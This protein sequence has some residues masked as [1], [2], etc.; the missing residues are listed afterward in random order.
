M[1]EGKKWCKPTKKFI[2]RLQLRLTHTYT[3]YKVDGKPC[4]FNVHSWCAHRDHMPTSLLDRS[5]ACCYHH[6]SQCAAEHEANI[7]NCSSPAR[8]RYRSSQNLSNAICDV[9]Y[10]WC[11]W[12]AKFLQIL[13]ITKRSIT[14]CPRVPR[15]N[16]LTRWVPY[17][18][19]IRHQMIISVA[20]WRIYPSWVNDKLRAWE[21]LGHSGM[22]WARLSRD[23]FRSKLE[24]I[25]FLSRVTFISKSFLFVSRAFVRFG[26][27]RSSFWFWQCLGARFETP[28]GH[29]ASFCELR[30]RPSIFWNYLSFFKAE[31][32]L[33]AWQLWW[34]PGWAKHFG[35]GTSK[36][37]M[38]TSHLGVGEIERR[39]TIDRCARRVAC[40]DPWSKRE[41]NTQRSQ[42]VI[43]WS[44]NPSSSTK[45]A[46]FEEPVT[47]TWCRDRFALHCFR[48]CGC[49]A[50]CR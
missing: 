35:D 16:Y 30:L 37:R 45:P 26:A 15:Q 33:L 42:R 6:A 36:V 46:S 18:E 8:Y 28:F 11:C 23:N 19:Y 27:K 13:K 34:S 9:T 47:K 5:N 12:L 2:H 49:T 3:V 50:T 48:V 17:D 25:W 38:K 41:K 10:S 31:P 39:R 29:R 4:E 20:V 7:W 14:V 32:V 44:L 22:F 40:G 1:I 21:G 43:V 24:H